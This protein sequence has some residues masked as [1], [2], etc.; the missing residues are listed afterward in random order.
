MTVDAKT[1]TCGQIWEL[2]R[3]SRD[4]DVI[5]AAI[6]S[7]GVGAGG[8]YSQGHEPTEADQRAADELLA[9]TWN[10]RQER[11]SIRG[12]VREIAEEAHRNIMDGAARSMYIAGRVADAL[13]GRMMQLNA[14]ERALVKRWRD[15]IEPIVGNDLCESEIEHNARGALLARLIGDAP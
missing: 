3:T 5:R 9:K 14:E 2:Y 15:D 4:P 1:I 6:V 10:E 11:N 8:V 13:A 7:I 12:I